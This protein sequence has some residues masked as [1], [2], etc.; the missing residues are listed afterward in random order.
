[1]TDQVTGLR[2]PF[3]TYTQIVRLLYV[4]GILLIKGQQEPYVQRA[5]KRVRRNALT[6][7]A[8]V[9]ADIDIDAEQARLVRELYSAVRYLDKCQAL[10]YALPAFKEQSGNTE[11]EVL[12]LIE[13]LSGSW[14]ARMFPMLPANDETALKNGKMTRLVKVLDKRNNGLE[15]LP[16]QKK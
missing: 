15:T 11:R 16:F 6:L 4:S 10:D 8:Q 13:A 7:L 1:M 2:N 3:G 9:K 14:S 12:A 5:A